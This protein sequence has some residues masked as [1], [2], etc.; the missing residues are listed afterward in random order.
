MERQSVIFIARWRR[1]VPVVRHRIYEC[2]SGQPGSSFALLTA[3]CSPPPTPHPPL[4]NP[5][6]YLVT[7]RQV[8][9]RVTAAPIGAQPTPAS[10]TPERRGVTNRPLKL[11]H[12]QRARE[13]GGLPWR[14]ACRRNTLL[15]R[16]A[17]FFTLPS[18]P[19]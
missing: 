13:A 7:P 19:R 11:S 16:L 3:L 14:Q 2:P 17:V 4:I 9:V 18:M 10:S 6:A 15:S 5:A 8:T 1:E 12:R